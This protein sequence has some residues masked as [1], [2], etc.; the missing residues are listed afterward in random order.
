MDRII[1]EVKQ[2]EANGLTEIALRVYAE[3]AGCIRLIGER[4]MP[5]FKQ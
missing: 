2:F 3:P 5:A 4:V 1:D